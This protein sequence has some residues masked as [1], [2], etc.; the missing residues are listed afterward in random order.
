M[1]HPQALNPSQRSYP[2]TA[3]PSLAIQ[4][5]PKQR[6]PTQNTLTQLPSTQNIPAQDA[7]TQTTSTQ[8]I[9][10]QSAPTGDGITQKNLGKELIPRNSSGQRVDPRIDALSWLVKEARPQKFCYEYHLHSHCRRASKPCPRKHS[11]SNLN[12]HQLNALQVLARESPCYRGNV[13]QEWRCCFGYRCPFGDHCN[14]GRLCR[15]PREM[16]ITG[17]KVVRQENALSASAIGVVG[18]LVLRA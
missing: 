9:P 16:H 2:F 18:E 14:K 6:H 17:L 4:E 15:F 5:L 10:A 11:I 8:N 7:A 3:I 1:V 13:C 12:I